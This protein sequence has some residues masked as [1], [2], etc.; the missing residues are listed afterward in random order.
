MSRRSASYATRAA[1]S[2]A[3]E[4]PATA[5][6]RTPRHQPTTP[7]TSPDDALAGYQSP[8]MTSPKRNHASGRSLTNRNP[9]SDRR[10]F[11]QPPAPRLRKLP[12][13]LSDGFE[14]RDALCVEDCGVGASFLAEDGANLGDPIGPRH[15]QPQQYDDADNKP[16]ARQKR[17]PLED[18]RRGWVDRSVKGRAENDRTDNRDPDVDQ[19]VPVPRLTG[20]P[21]VHDPAQAQQDVHDDDQQGSGSR[22]E[23]VV[24]QRLAE[25]GVGQRV[26]HQQRHRDGEHGDRHG[27][28]NGRLEC[29]VG[30][31]ERGWQNALAA[32]SEHGSRGSGCS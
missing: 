9:D 29:G 12:D 31:A 6:A 23:V 1:P 18:A 15:A 22:P 8:P 30:L 16:G 32:H 24:A 2:S 7:R 4:S 25:I 27:G 20:A 10:R 26:A 3:P 28:V 19:R 21:E 17:S 11:W 5:T 14:V 13:R